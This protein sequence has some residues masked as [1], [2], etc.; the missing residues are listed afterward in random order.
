MSLIFATQLTAV[1]TAVLAAFAIATAWY[2]RQA[3]RKQSQEV[4]AIERQVTDGQ[5]TARQQAELL[6]IQAEH[7]EVLRAQLDDQRE[8]SAAQAGV[9]KLQADELRAA[10]DARALQSLERRQ[11]YASTVVAWQDEPRRSGTGWVVDAHV[12]N[13]GERPVRDVSARWYSGG[14]RIREPEGLTAC[15]MPH[16]RKS[17]ECR[18]DDASIRAGLNAIV[19]FRTVGDDWW[20]AGTDGTLVGGMEVTDAPVRP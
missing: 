2:A 12:L 16:D 19:E 11:Q 10:A 15:L 17:F 9:L 5:E 6:K 1:A 8:A 20:E 7:L 18:A 14:A 4:T 3:F 13:T